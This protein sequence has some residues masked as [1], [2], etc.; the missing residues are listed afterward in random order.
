MRRSPEQAFG[1]WRTEKLV[2]KITILVVENEAIIR[3]GTVHMLQDAGYAVVE[4]PNADAAIQIL[5]A[6]N[7]IR[8]VF[9]DIKMPGSL[10]GLRLAKAIRDRWPPVHLIVASG[11]NAPT[12]DEFPKMGRFIRKPYTAEHVLVA[13]ED[14]FGPN[15]APY[16]YFDDVIQNYG[17]VVFQ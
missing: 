12:E 11:L 15:P 9:T 4:A 1:R 7:D 10:C 3:M 16:R 5:E 13:L 17:K 2:E 14:L 8:V 6:R